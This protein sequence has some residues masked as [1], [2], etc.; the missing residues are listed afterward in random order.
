MKKKI[1]VGLV[2]ALMLA[3]TFGA[4]AAETKSKQ[5]PWMASY[6][7]PGHVNVY[8]AIGYYFGGLPFTGGAEFIIGKFDLA[9]IPLE[10]GV[11]AQAILGFDSYYSGG[12]DWGVAP[13]AS[14]HWGVDLGKPWKFDWYIALGLGLFGGSYQTFFFT[15]APV[16][17]GFASYDAVIWE[18]SDNIGIM[19]EY[20]YIGWTSVYGVGVTFKL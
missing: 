15:N 13:L 9:G 17:F 12:I 6:N 14:L 4:F 5:Y 18:L 8:G 10:W 3:S 11:M 16:G 19:L 20:G 1:V 2:L 7:T